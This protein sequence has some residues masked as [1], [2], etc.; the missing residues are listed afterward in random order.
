MATL[1]P[2]LE[3]QPYVAWV[4]P[5]HG[6]SVDVNLDGFRIFY[7]RQPYPQW[8]VNIAEIH[9]QALGLGEDVSPWLRVPP[10]PRGSGRV[11]IHKSPRFG[12]P[13]F[14]WNRFLRDYRDDDL[15]C[16]GL[17]E[18]HRTLEQISGRRLSYCPTR[19]LLELAG[20]LAGSRLFVGNQSS[21]MAVALGLGGPVVQ[22]TSLASPNC[23][24]DRP[25]FRS[26][27]VY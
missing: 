2:L 21:P 20:V 5:W 12:S 1:T 4:R 16:V 18:E 15:L 23:L 17:P 22:E 26:Y 6:K 25:G 3:A 10:D 11:V 27:M 19:D 24:F 8:F 13:Y 7:Q 9:L 14:R